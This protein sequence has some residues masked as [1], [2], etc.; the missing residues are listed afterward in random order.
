MERL[1][2]VSEA[3]QVLGVTSAYLYRMARAGEI[4]TIKIGK[5]QIRFPEK[6]LKRW[7]KEK[8]R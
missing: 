5:R 6:E 7:L 2:K 8:N 1:L 3:S 4:R